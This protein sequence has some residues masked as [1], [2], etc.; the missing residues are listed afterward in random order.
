M[1]KIWK[2]ALIMLIA[3]ILFLALL[4]LFFQFDFDAHPSPKVAEC[5]SISL[6]AGPA[7]KANRFRKV[8]LG[9]N[10]REEWTTTVKV[11]CID[12]DTFDGGLELV[13]AG[14][15]MQTR[16]LRLKN[17]QGVE[18]M[19]RSVNKDPSPVLSNNLQ[20]TYIDDVVQDMI[21]VSHPYGMLIVPEMAKALG[22][23]YLNPQLVYLPDN[24]KL[25]RY[26]ESFGGML[27]TIEIRPDNDLGNYERFGFPKDADATHTLYKHLRNNHYNKV[28]QAMF[29]KNRLFD[30]FINDWDRH[31]GQWRWAVFKTDSSM[32]FKPIAR[33]RDQVFVRFEGLM[34]GITKL[35]IFGWQKINDFEGEVENFKSLNWNARYLDRL[36]L[37]ELTRVQWLQIAREMQAQLT[38]EVIAKAVK[39]LP[40]EIYPVSGPE[41]IEVLKERR[42]LIR[43]MA[44]EHYDFLAREVHIALSDMDEHIVV[45]PKANGQLLI[46]VFAPKGGHLLY[47]RMFEPG[48]TKNIVVHPYAGHHSID[49]VGEEALSIPV[50]I[51][52]GRGKV[53]M[54]REGMENIEL[55]PDSSFI[56]ETA[57]SQSW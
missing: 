15:G 48:Q 54:G 12:I 21:S 14:G 32:Y 36:L 10:Y 53:K 40:P 13:K 17:K 29:A 4:P 30:M 2:A 55:L 16:S 42:A 5:D 51:Y 20:K 45:T 18:F 35:N 19:I 37:N 33:D 50:R 31:E 38:D 57:A 8:M 39:K 22:L 52:N 47:S 26:R 7:Y 56:Y 28:D 44:A 11:P 9:A 24:E 34:P 49:M 41:M 46:E 3:L 25:G 23:Y 6:E 1:K 43:D 27:G